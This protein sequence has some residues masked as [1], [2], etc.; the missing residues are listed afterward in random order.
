MS[1]LKQDGTAEP[2]SRDQQFLRRERGQGKVI[3]PVQLA[4][5][6]IGNHSPVDTY[7]AESADQ[8]CTPHLSLV[9]RFFV[10][11]GLQSKHAARQLYHGVLLK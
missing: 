8:T 6:R 1:G 10:A 4:M 3:F 9:C 7:S 5:S 11:I 2:V